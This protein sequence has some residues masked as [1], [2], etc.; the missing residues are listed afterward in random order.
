[1]FSASLRLTLPRR[2]R[3]SLAAATRKSG[4]GCRL[5]LLHDVDDREAR[6]G[7]EAGG[8]E[9]GGAHVSIVAAV[10]SSHVASSAAMK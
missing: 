7:V 8:G 10:S 1:L 9:E 6:I 4:R 2:Y 5:A 3:A